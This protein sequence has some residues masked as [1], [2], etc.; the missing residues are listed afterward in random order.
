[1]IIASIS[2]L[3]K[4]YPSIR[5]LDDICLAIKSGEKIGLVGANGTGKTTLLEIIFGLVDIESGSVDIIKGTKVEYLPQSFA[6]SIDNKNKIDVSL[7]DF[8]RSGF[9]ELLTLKEKIESLEKKISA[10]LATRKEK[11]RYSEALHSFEF[12]NGYGIEARVEK[13]M[14]G[15]GF[16][17]DMFDVSL[18]ILSGGEKN[19]ALL[20]RLLVVNPDF[21]LLDEPTN[22]L[23]INGIEFLE[24]YLKTSPSAALIVSHDRRFLDR[25]VNKIWEI[26]AA[27]IKSYQ[28]NYSVYLQA[29]SKQE[30]LELKAYNQQR[31]FIKKTKTF[32]AKNIAGQ[33]TKQAQSRRKML[34]RLERL[35]KPASAEK[36]IGIRLDD[37]A[38]SDR[39]ICRFDGVKFSYEEKPILKSA[40]FTIERGEKI[41]LIGSNGSGK[42]TILEL[43]ANRIKQDSG[44]I[45]RGKKITPGYFRQ[46]RDEFRP[47]DKVIDIIARV[48]PDY[49]EGK[50]RDYLASFL[51]V[52]DDVFRQIGTFSGGQQSRLALAM[53]LAKQPNFLALD[54]PTNHLDIQSREVLEQALAEYNGTLLVV[55][56]DRYFLDSVV[57]KIYN[58]HDG[59]IKTYLGNY[60]YFESKRLEIKQ[61]AEK[62]IK[63]KTPKTIKQKNKRINPLIIQ[64]IEKEIESLELKL[65]DIETM[66]ISREHISD[67]AKL[68]S[69]QDEKNEL[70]KKILLMYEK[71]DELTSTEK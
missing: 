31:E 10:G 55:S 70:E 18:G 64:K 24:N 9:G 40:E 37:I 4:S 38:R 58:L 15:L 29:K 56:H 63:A 49:T 16:S 51:F 67:W 23:D 44:E 3:T 22:H 39:I 54:E 43:A 35:N 60:S 65:T 68:Q 6:D 30:E 13:I 46:I 41:G 12:H 47:A 62:I 52:G 61:A 34:A 66:I 2:N 5:V 17:K 8:V 20:A 48:L 36:S 59:Y 28:G 26:H 57:D 53:L 19:R 50:Q 45:I 21:M 25:T 14:A 32:I 27:R 7:F 42:T 33:K 71:L 11:N 69:M 1:M